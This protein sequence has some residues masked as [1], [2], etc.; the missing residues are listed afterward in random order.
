MRS[1]RRTHKLWALPAVAA[2]SLSAFAGLASA[3]TVIEQGSS[4]DLVAPPSPNC[5]AGAIT[6]V[7]EVQFTS[8]G[9]PIDA[10]VLGVGNGLST[11]V[12][13]EDFN[14]VDAGAI[15]IVEIIT[16]DAHTG[17]AL[18]PAQDNE[19]VAIEFLLDGVIQATSAFTPDVEDGVNSAWVVS[20]L[21]ELELPEGADEARVVHFNEASNNDSVVVASA[22]ASFTGLAEPIAEAT[23]EEEEAPAEEAEEETE[24][25]AP[26][27]ETDEAEEVDEE[28]APVEE[29]S[30]EAPTLDELI[31]QNSG[32]LAAP[33]IELDETVETEVEGATQDP[34][35]ADDAADTDD[36][37]AEADDATDD[38]D[39]AEADAAV[40]D[41]EDEADD[42]EEAE[43]VASEGPMAEML[44]ATGAN[45]I[46]FIVIALGIMI[47]GIAFRI[48]SQDP[49]ELRPF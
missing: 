16:Y 47:F 25:E 41:P 3:Q 44:A 42:D 28:E 4:D 10:M 19:R 36:T 38:D 6:L 40:A 32:P 14:G 21:G 18:W 37:A 20:S 30:G 34:A 2:L 5:P 35:D 29:E 26:V 39:A 45:E 11:T 8:A 17:R 48:Q 46:A 15:E 49:D 1:T 27:E 13:I 23:P 22:C 7:P 9:S 31:M 43:E 33:L 12:D 24:E